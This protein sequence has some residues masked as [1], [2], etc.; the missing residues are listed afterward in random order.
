MCPVVR[1]QVEGMA[2]REEGFGIAWWDIT[3]F[4][5]S[6]SVPFAVGV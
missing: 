4:E 5:S 6:P 2:V 3:S 1:K